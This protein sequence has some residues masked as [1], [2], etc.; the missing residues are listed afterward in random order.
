MEQHPISDIPVALIRYLDISLVLAMAPVVVLGDLPLA[1]YAIGAV[2]WIVTRYGVDLV[3]RR[4]R[5][6]GNAGKEAAL[7]LAAMMG[8]VFAVAIA[9]LVARFA[10]GR[11]DGIMAASVVLIAF[12]VRLLVTLALRGGYRAEAG[13][14]T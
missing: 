8:R 10:A 14:S 9:V 7:V 12:T 5:R 3:E 11:D 4:A 1:G 13:G 2:T 6:S